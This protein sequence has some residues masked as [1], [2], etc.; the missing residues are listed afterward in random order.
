[1]KKTLFSLRQWLRSI[2][3]GNIAFVSVVLISLFLAFVFISSELTWQ[4]AVV[5]LVL[6]LVY[7]V[8]GIPGEKFVEG[9][10]SPWLTAGY[11][12]VQ[13]NL[14]L[15]IAILSVGTAW[16]VLMP[17][18]SHSMVLYR[19]RAAWV[20]NAVIIVIFMLSIQ[21][22]SGNWRNTIPN[23]MAFL[24]GVV[25]V[26]VFT[27]LAQREESARQ[28]VERLAGELSDANQKLR[29]Y[30]AKVEDLAIAEERNRMAREIHDGLGHYLTAINIQIKAA[31]AVMG[32][33]AAKAQDALGKAQSLAVDALADV[34]RSVAALRSDPVLNRPLPETVEVLLA[35]ARAA[36][37][38]AELSV[39]GSPRPLEPQIELACY[40]IVQEGLTNI[41]KHAL[42]SKVNVRLEYLPDA[43]RLSVHDNGIGSADTDNGFGLLGLRERL[44]LLDGK[45]QVITSPGEG[46]TLEVEIPLESD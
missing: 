31:Q 25:F 12:I 6:C 18:V 5:L 42:A 39:L 1:M 36:G 46:F 45:I 11:F 26:A 29:Q 23:G 37:V 43:V 19:P 30:A 15:A 13:I 32:R 17:L 16:L 7:T 21:Y 14:G 10:H 4:R 2:E 40:R 44:Q 38:V 33:D 20:V 35:D 8:I 9:R 34:R 24:A 22:L 41:R 27:G 28:D 3:G